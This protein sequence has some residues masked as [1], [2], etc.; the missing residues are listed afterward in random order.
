ML[1]A[2]IKDDVARHVTRMIAC[3]WLLNGA[4]SSSDYTSSDAT[5]NNGL[6]VIWKEAVVA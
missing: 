6:D 5:M 4:A 1:L 3:F 2:V